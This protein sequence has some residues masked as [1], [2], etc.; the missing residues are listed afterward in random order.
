MKRHQ[1]S[2]H[3]RHDRVGEQVA[4]S[5]LREDLERWLTELI[6]FDRRAVRSFV[7]HYKDES[8]H[9]DAAHFLAYINTLIGQV[10]P[11]VRLHQE[12]RARLLAYL[13]GELREEAGWCRW[14][15]LEL[16][17]ASRGRRREYCGNAC[18]QRAKRYRRS[19]PAR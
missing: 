17:R 9:F 11:R 6:D 13:G 4:D 7:H 1:Q 16:P 3:I 8:G 15:S 18:R 2:R 12:H 19:M 5:F 10:F 14:C